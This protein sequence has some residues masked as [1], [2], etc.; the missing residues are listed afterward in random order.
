MQYGVMAIALTTII[1]EVL[2]FFFNVYPVT[3]YIGF[4][5]KEHLLDALPPFLMSTI[6]SIIVYL[7]GKIISVDTVCLA[8]QVIAG[9]TLYLGLSVVTKNDSFIYLK[10][11][12]ANKL[13]N[14][15]EAE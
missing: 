1:N 13:R 6:M 2:A 8:V 10:N 9:V 12:L 15:K 11:M 14:N 7:I 3:K 5:F 4:D